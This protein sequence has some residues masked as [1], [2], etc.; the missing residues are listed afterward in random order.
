MRMV[1]DM[2]EGFRKVAD[3]VNTL[4][5]AVLIADELSGRLQARVYSGVAH[6]AV[7]LDHAATRAYVSRIELGLIAKSIVTE[8]EPG[9][10]SRFQEVLDHA[11]GLE[12]MSR[13][14]AAFKLGSMVDNVGMERHY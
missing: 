13:E 12:A 3:G 1:Q 9:D 11:V 5:G 8:L 10:Y 4:A 6:A 2:I 14:H 7:A